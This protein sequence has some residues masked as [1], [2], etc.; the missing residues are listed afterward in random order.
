MAGRAV[1]GDHQAGG[2]AAGRRSGVLL[3]LR[4]RLHLFHA[5]SGGQRWPRRDDRGRDERRAAARCPRFPGP[6]AGPGP[7]RLRL[8]H[9]V[10]GADRVHHVREA[11]RLLDRPQVGDRC[12]DPDPEPDRCAEVAQHRAEGQGGD[13]GRGLGPAPRHRQGRDQDRRRRL[14]AR[15]SWP[16]AP[17]SICGGSG[18]SSTTDPPDC[19]ARRCGPPTRAARASPR[20]ARRYSPR[21]PR[22]GTRS[23]SPRNRPLPAV[24]DLLGDQSALA[25]LRGG[26]LG[27][28]LL[29]LLLEELALL[30][31]LGA[32]RLGIHRVEQDAGRDGGDGQRPQR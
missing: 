29:L 28:P 25:L 16:T 1:R 2:R 3:L 13:R 5:V 27:S 22:A 24:A 23:S 9:Q 11:L 4:L 8:G 12:P 17:G 20:S 6:D 21:V 15:P 14:A 32:E 30:G 19:T 31:L 26:H 18:R 7:V 10:A